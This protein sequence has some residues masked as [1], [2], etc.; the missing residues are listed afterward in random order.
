MEVRWDEIRWVRAGGHSYGINPGLCWFWNEPWEGAGLWS[1]WAGKLWGARQGVG[2]PQLWQPSLGLLLSGQWETVLGRVW[3]GT[4]SN[5]RVEGVSLWLTGL[6]PGSQ[7]PQLCRL[8]AKGHLTSPESSL[9]TPWISGGPL[10][11][12]LWRTLWL[13]SSALCPLHSPPPDCPVQTGQQLL[14]E[15]SS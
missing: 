4:E 12:G 13:A 7:T 10:G 9:E 2:I 14:W 8:Q 5:S 6:L 11:R 3:L 15:Q 1:G